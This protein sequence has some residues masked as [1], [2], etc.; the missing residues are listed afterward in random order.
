[1]EMSELLS[2]ARGDA[3]AELL[4]TNARIVNV[5][6]GEIENADIAIA[7]GVI[8]GVGGGYRGKETIDLAGAFV[9]PD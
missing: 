3:P 4:L 5:Y 8:V 1:M 7:A 6:S 9:A 2:I